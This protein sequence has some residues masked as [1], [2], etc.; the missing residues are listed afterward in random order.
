MYCICTCRTNEQC[1]ASAALYSFHL[2][3]ITLDRFVEPQL[4]RECFGKRRLCPVKGSSAF[5]TQQVTDTIL[6]MHLL[7]A[8]STA[9]HMRIG[10]QALNTAS[11]D[12]LFTALQIQ[13]RGMLRAPFASLTII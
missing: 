6:Y 13:I 3:H 5:T 7:L 11:H 9:S 4:H 1:A 8:P 10:L 2:V 12:E